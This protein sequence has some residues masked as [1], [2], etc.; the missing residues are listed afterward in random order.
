[1]I[2]S[3]RSECLADVVLLLAVLD[4]T[5]C[6]RISIHPDR[7]FPDVEVE[8]EGELA[9]KDLQLAMAQIEDGHVM[10]ET[11]AQAPREQNSMCRMCS[12]FFY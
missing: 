9:L 1:M 3:F 4:C 10:L 12:D 2:I 7:V 5:Q 6:E 8:V 11:V